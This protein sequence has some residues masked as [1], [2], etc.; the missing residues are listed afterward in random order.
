[1]CRI[2]LDRKIR[3]SKAGRGDCPHLLCGSGLEHVLLGKQMDG[4]LM[5]QT[6]H[7]R[8]CCWILNSL[9]SKPKSEPQNV[10]HQ[11]WDCHHGFT[12]PIISPSQSLVPFLCPYCAHLSSLVPAT[13]PGLGCGSEI[14]CLPGMREALH[15]VP[16]LRTK[17]LWNGSSCLST[18][19]CYAAARENH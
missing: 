9:C 10:S 16:A 1:M 12:I 15:S 5:L 3:E 19:W 8:G 17:G 11:K 6:Q 14:E 13:G 18:H 7:S 2:S 4:C